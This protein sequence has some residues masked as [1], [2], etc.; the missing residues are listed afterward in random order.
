MFSQ[1]FFLLF[2][3]VSIR[4]EIWPP[5]GHLTPNNYIPPPSCKYEQEKVY[6]DIIE[7]VCTTEEIEECEMEDS[8]KMEL[9]CQKVTEEVCDEDECDFNN[10]DE[11]ERC[12]EKEEDCREK[13]RIESKRECL[14]ET[15]IEKKCFRNVSFL[16]F[17]YF[18]SLVDVNILIVSRGKKS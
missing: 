14:Y 3:G 12:D 10:D 15:R 1:M 18:L 4:A 13:T 16:N 11:C 17:N 6:E 5:F 9:Q 8:P 2:L 7:E